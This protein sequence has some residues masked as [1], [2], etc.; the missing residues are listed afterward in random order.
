MRP[1]GTFPPWA[2]GTLSM[3]FSSATRERLDEEP[4]KTSL[5]T[6]NK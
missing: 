2:L 3:Q 4:G 6:H 1:L 5:D